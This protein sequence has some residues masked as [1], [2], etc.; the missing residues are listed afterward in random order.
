VAGTAPE[1]CKMKCFGISSVETSDS[2]TTA[3]VSYISCEVSELEH[4]LVVYFHILTYIDIVK[5][6]TIITATPQILL[7]PTQF[8]GIILQISIRFHNIINKVITLKFN[9]LNEV[10]FERLFLSFTVWQVVLEGGLLRHH[11]GTSLHFAYNLRITHL[12]LSAT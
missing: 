3:L 5:T 12:T 9:Y 11:S 8:R 7:N 10:V 6:L 4:N 2:A 1:S